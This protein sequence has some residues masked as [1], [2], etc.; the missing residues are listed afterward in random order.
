MEA[1]NQVA[2]GREP[3]KPHCLPGQRYLR[4][5]PY[6]HRLSLIKCCSALNYLHIYSCKGPGLL[7]YCLCMPF[8]VRYSVKARTDLSSPA[9]RVYACSMSALSSLRNLILLSGSER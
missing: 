9:A 8:A 6:T 3:G 1:A 5:E 7:N 2:N 4:W